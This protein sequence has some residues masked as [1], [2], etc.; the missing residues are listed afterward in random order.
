[1]IRE[2][3]DIAHIA[4][5]GGISLILLLFSAMA[6]GSEVIV[7]TAAILGNGLGFRGRLLLAHA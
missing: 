4:V 5:L 6:S 2:S 7:D 1:M 3:L